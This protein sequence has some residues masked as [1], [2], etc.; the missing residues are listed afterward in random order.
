MPSSTQILRIRG[1][2]MGSLSRALAV[3]SAAFMLM[4]CF[5]PHVYGTYV[6]TR[7]SGIEL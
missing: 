6:S 2:R 1:V 4:A 7:S 3:V 5:D